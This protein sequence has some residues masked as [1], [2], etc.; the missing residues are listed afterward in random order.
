MAQAAA[1]CGLTPMSLL[2]LPSP[3]APP[4]P[5]E[6]GLQ[7]RA[8]ATAADNATVSEFLDWLLPMLSGFGGG[9]GAG[10]ADAAAEA[11]A[12]D[13]GYASPDYSYSGSDADEGEGGDSGDGGGA[14][15]AESEDEERGGSGSDADMADAGDSGGCWHLGGMPGAGCAAG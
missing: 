13:G 9:A 4:P 7:R 11:A 14:A 5:Q 10:A 6:R 15:A 8:V 3:D 2:N 1:L 12:G